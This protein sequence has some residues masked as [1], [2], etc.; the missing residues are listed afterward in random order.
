[1]E[2]QFEL[3]ADDDGYID[4][5]CPHCQRLFRWHH[6]PLEGAP[7]EADPALEYHCPYCGGSASSDEWW[8]REQAEAL[9]QA[10]LAAMMPDIQE[11]LKSPE[12]RG[13]LVEVTVDA[14]PSLPPPTPV[15]L[16]DALP[17]VTVASPCHP[18]EPVKLL[19][20]WGPPLHC[21]VCGTPFAI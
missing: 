4:R 5:E 19:G 15:E 8:T 16:H 12:R 6:G 1:V 17:S 20:A 21:L 11:Q 2:I 7:E 18:Y 9:Q 3:S 14:A 10:A 13:G